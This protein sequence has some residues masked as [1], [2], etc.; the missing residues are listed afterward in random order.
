MQMHLSMLQRR[1][2]TRPREA[3]R[4]NNNYHVLDPLDS[5][6]CSVQGLEYVNQTVNCNVVS[7]APFLTD[8][9]L[10]QKRELKSRLE[11]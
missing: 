2:V 4:V 5:Q 8:T 1:A 3:S 10:S 9:R 7:H 11:R 6:F